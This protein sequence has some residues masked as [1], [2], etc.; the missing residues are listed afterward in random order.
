MQLHRLCL[1][2]LRRTCRHVKQKCVWVCLC[3]A[4][5]FPEAKWRSQIQ[6]PRS[7]LHHWR[8]PSWGRFSGR[9]YWPLDIACWMTLSPSPLLRFCGTKSW[10][11]FN[12]GCKKKCPHYIVQSRVECSSCWHF[13]CWM[14]FISFF[15][16]VF[17]CLQL[18]SSNFDFLL[19]GFFR[20]MIDFVADPTEESW[21]G[22][23]Y[24]VL[25]LI[26][27]TVQT[28]AQ[29]HYFFVCERVGLQIRAAIIASVYRKVKKSNNLFYLRNISDRNNSIHFVGF[30]SLCVCHKSLF[31][32]VCVRAI[33]VIAHHQCGEEVQ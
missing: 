23:F 33:I 27:A 21:K 8:T 25:M 15:D 11:T 17:V 20:L 18:F 9:L 7:I 32:L 10:L 5:Y 14:E 30:S 2:Q 26:A 22:Y 4:V 6:G 16:H 19:C 29:S 13:R 1:F 28:F 12:S 31:F 3:M 24:A